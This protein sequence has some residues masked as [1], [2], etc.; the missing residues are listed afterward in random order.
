[1]LLTKIDEKNKQM[2]IID[3]GMA[4]LH[5]N[6]KKYKAM[7]GSPFF[8]APEVIEGWYDNKCDIW[9]LGVTTFY[10]LT[11]YLPFTAPDR[12]RLFKK[13]ATASIN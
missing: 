10:I 9:S 5:L 8:V 3:F 7:A 4:T 11:G 1:M 12:E 2:K 6:D 13:I